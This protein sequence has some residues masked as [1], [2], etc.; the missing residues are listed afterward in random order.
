MKTLQTIM[1][2][3][4]DL[5]GSFNWDEAKRKIESLN[6]QNYKG[7]SDW[8]LPTKEELNEIYL[9]RDTIGGFSTHLYWSSSEYSADAALLQGFGSGYQYIFNKDNDK[10]VRCVRSI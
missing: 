9:S 4:Q 1:V 5:V 8:R 6:S 7:F 10:L 3:D 2:D